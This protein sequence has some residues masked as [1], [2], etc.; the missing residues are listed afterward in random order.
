MSPVLSKT[1]QRLLENKTIIACNEQLAL[2]TDG[3]YDNYT[4]CTVKT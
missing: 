4:L 1:K 3:S 2:F